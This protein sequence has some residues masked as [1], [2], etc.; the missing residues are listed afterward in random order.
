MRRQRKK[1]PKTG[2]KRPRSKL[3]IK[4]VIPQRSVGIQAGRTSEDPSAPLRDDKIFESPIMTNAPLLLALHCMDLTSLNDADMPETIDA[5]CAS[6][7]QSVLGKVAAVCVYPRFVRQA[8][9]SLVGKDIG[10]ATVINFPDGQSTIEKTVADTLAAI[11]DG[12]TEI[13]IVLDYKNFIH[14]DHQTPADLLN[15]CRSACGNKAKMKVILESAAFDNQ[16]LLYEAACLAL[17]CGADFLKTSTGK[18]PSGGATV[19]AATTMLQ[20]I[21]DKT[22]TA[23]L[24]ISGGVRTA[25]DAARYIDLAKSMMSEN[26]V[27][28]QHFR[29]GASSLLDNLLIILL[30]SAHTAKLG[31]NTY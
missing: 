20:A 15:A 21:K 16:N 14:D 23:G 4:T 1:N 17:D 24:K 30:P 3:V 29:L 26:W 28:P 7:D 18:H 11:N 25:E 27:E 9:S 31:G 19:E 8:A 6:A 12:A 13:D 10:I 2:T 5:L 22:S